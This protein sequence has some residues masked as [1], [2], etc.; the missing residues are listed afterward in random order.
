MYFT[1]ELMYVKTEGRRKEIR[2]GDSLKGVLSDQR[3]QELKRMNPPLASD[4]NPYGKQEVIVEADSKSF[5]DGK[6]K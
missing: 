5:L 4:I 1:G 6:K 3:I 2:R